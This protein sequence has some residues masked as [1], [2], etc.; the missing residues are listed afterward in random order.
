[1]K[2][3]DL[4]R[5]KRLTKAYIYDAI[6]SVAAEETAEM[7]QNMFDSRV[8]E[9]GK[10]TTLRFS[11]GYCDWPL[12]EQRKLFR[13]IDSSAI[14]VELRPSCLMRPRKSIS[15]IFGV[16]SVVDIKKKK[17]NPCISCSH[18]TCSV[19]RVA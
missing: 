2:I 5:K 19:R 8:K 12:E 11:P 18:K 14:G 6:G 1:M 4:M 9:K 15:G 17:S 13:V 3:H 7:F 16:G 10:T